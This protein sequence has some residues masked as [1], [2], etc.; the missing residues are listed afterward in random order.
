MK[1]FIA[2]A[3]AAIMMS[4]PI[5]VMAAGNITV[6]TNGNE[7]ADRGI[8]IEGRTMVPV[9]GV[10]ENFGFKVEWDGT[11][12]TATLS[13]DDTVIKMTNG[14]KSFTLNDE[15]VTPD[16]PQQI[17]EGRFMLPLRAVGEAIGAE[18][19]WDAST[20]TAS[21]DN[22]DN[23]SSSNNL[24]DNSN[25]IPNNNSSDDSKKDN[26]ELKGDYTTPGVTIEETDP[27][28]M[29]DIKTEIEF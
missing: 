29:S 11:T 21:L 17:V 3:L 2:S 28:N 15:I 23:N 20:K 16:V 10:F 12:K 7:I 25:N 24:S 4:T 1:K 18:V 14:E 26:E 8:I 27:F 5:T 9:R 22:A 19:N 6:V 13:D